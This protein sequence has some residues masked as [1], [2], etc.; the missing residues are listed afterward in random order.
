[1]LGGRD[2]GIISRSPEKRNMQDANERKIVEL[3]QE[4]DELAKLNARLL[5]RLDRH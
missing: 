5:R 2:G 3:T 1:M 4:R